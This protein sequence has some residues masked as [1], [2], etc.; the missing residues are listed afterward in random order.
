MSH[1]GH[2]VGDFLARRL[3]CGQHERAERHLLGCAHC[4]LLVARERHRLHLMQ[5]AGG[6]EPTPDLAQRILSHTQSL[7][8]GGNEQLSLPYRA[9]RR[10]RAALAAGAVVAVVGV[11]GCGAAY[12]AG[13]D[14]AP[15][16]AEVTARSVPA[17][18][19]V[20]APA[21]STVRA[22]SVQ[23]AATVDLAE[24]EQ[25]KTTGWACPELNS[26]GFS[27]RSAEGFVRDG[28]PTLE[29]VLSNGANVVTVYEQR[30][31]RGTAA[32]GSGIPLN[33]M[34]G[35]DAM[36]DGFEATSADGAQLWLHHGSPWQM[37]FREDDATYTVSTDLPFSALDG[38][39]AAIAAQERQRAT[40]AVSGGTTGTGPTVL[41]GSGSSGNDWLTRIARGF[42][43][44]TSF[45]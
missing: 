3:P 25:L 8:T 37:I 45:R 27:L 34:T 4:R 44:L 26:M 28:I 17:Q 23:H 41:P 6:P 19:P 36:A 30:P 40:D 42:S 9:H 38:M 11:L 35:H 31:Q 12:L 20:A 5:A 24:I 15:A 14:D 39:T 10:A 18:W 21:A 33:A 2:Y 29:L 13:G 7:N 43:R 1:L 22:S 16:R 32:G